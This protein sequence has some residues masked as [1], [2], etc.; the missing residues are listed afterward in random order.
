MDSQNQKDSSEQARDHRHGEQVRLSGVL[1]CSTVEEAATVRQYLPAHISLTRAEPGCLSFEVK[2]TH[3][4]M[5]WQVDEVFSAADA[6][7]AHQ[8]RVAASDWGRFTGGIERRY[9]VEGL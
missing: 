2:P 4:P 8:S 1:V 9:T 6:F 5:V 3:E 7:R